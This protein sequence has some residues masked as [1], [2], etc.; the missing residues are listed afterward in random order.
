MQFEHRRKHGQGGGTLA[1]S[2]LS[3]MPYCSSSA[4]AFAVASACGA[5]VCSIRGASTGRAAPGGR[6]LKYQTLARL[7]VRPAAGA[8]WGQVPGYL[9]LIGFLGDAVLLVELGGL[10]RRGGLR[11]ASLRHDL[12]F[13]L[14][15]EDLAHFLHLICDGV[16]RGPACLGWQAGPQV[17][18]GP[19]INQRCRSSRGGQACR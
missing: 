9:G 5:R 4:P 8:R 12:V 16:S 18:L 7:R 1:F 11:L 10:R 13:L 17:S 6:A 14:L 3:E 15:A 19:Q 2:A